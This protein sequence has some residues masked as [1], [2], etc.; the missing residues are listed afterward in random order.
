MVGSKGTDTSGRHGGMNLGL[1]R[2]IESNGDKLA[3]MCWRLYVTE[4]AIHQP[5]SSQ[6]IVLTGAPLSPIGPGIPSSPGVPG[7]P[8]GPWNPGCPSGP[9][10]PWGPGSPVGPVAP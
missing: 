5:K 6:F 1:G 2:K 3:R 4:D 9:G 8:I 7:G 10:G